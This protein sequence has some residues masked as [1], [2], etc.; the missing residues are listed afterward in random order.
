MFVDGLCDEPIVAVLVDPFEI[1]VPLE[2]SMDLGRNR[3]MHL[4]G[5]RDQNLLVGSGLLP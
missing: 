4:P 1:L 3:M 2:R 5:A